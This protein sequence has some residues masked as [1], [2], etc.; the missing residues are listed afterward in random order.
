MEKS[1]NIFKNI[2]ELSNFFAQKLIL[3][4]KAI[5]EGQFFS[6]ALSGGST[7]RAVFQYLALNFKTQIAWEKI[8]VFW[9]DERCVPPE[10]EES[11]YRMAK[12]S[13]L[14]QVSINVSNIFRIRG[15]DMP[16]IEIDRYA[17]EVRQHINLVNGIPQF[18]FIMLGLGNDGHTASIFPKNLDLF[19]SEEL[20]EMAEH[21]Q[22]NQKRITATG[23]LINQASV[24]AFLVTG[25]SKSEMVNIILGYKKDWQKLPAS[26]VQPK[27]G[28][29][30]WLIDDKAASML[31]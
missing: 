9:G 21:P 4:V 14:D 31:E 17:R 16:S 19:N 2:D 20:F 8:M 12:E 3:G 5:P 6:I 1:I 10:S 15:E 25:E 29:L 11:N 7:P 24:V 26:K 28:E 18:N 22:T 23:K 13:L 30:I 27:D